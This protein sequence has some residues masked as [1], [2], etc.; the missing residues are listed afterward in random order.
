[1]KFFFHDLELFCMLCL[2]SVLYC[3]FYYVF[4]IL[5]NFKNSNNHSSNSKNQSNFSIFNKSHCAVNQD[6][7]RLFV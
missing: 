4:E 6:F 2:N 3:T 1:M 5:K 7:C